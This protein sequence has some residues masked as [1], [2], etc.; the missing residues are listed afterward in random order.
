MAIS[1]DLISENEFNKNNPTKEILPSSGI[2]SQTP[3]ATQVYANDLPNSTVP[4]TGIQIT[5]T[6]TPPSPGAVAY[7]PSNQH[8]FFITATGRAP[9]LDK[10]L[11]ND[12]NF[13]IDD[14]LI[15]NNYIHHDGSF[16][17]NP[18]SFLEQSIVTFNI[19][20]LGNR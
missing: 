20:N 13:F 3:Y 7:N 14:M 2:Y 8:S 6:T 15:F 11:L 18:Q 16:E 4:N 12:S 5:T 17:F 1:Q 10:A 19:Y 9:P